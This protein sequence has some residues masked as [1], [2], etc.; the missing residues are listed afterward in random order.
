MII[1]DF[2]AQH[3]LAPLKLH[4][5]CGARKLPGWVNIDKFDYDPADTSRT[6]SDYDIQADICDLP[7]R[8]GTVDQIL[9]VHVVEHF[10]RW[11]TIDN[12]RHW[13]SKLR[14]GGLL[15][16]EMPDL[17]KC[18]EWYL[19]GEKAPH[20]K[21]KLGPLNMGYTQF[22]GN[23]WD[24]LDYETHRFVWRMQ[25]FL[26]ALRDTGFWIVEGHHNA[27]FHQPGR[28]MFVVAGKPT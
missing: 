3:K 13:K 19:S 14:E 20:I 6:G 2:A 11:Q 17:D 10:T 25:D 16:V 28:D 15:L 26:Q 22:Y 18:I 1:N 24:E 4:L 7:V 9:L 23:Q 21:T 12:L 8:D 5:G 27:Q